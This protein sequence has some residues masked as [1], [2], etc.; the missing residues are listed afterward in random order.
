MGAAITRITYSLKTEN[1][2]FPTRTIGPRAVNRN[3]GNVSV[4][5]PLARILSAWPQKSAAPTSCTYEPRNCRILLGDEI[6]GVFQR[7]VAGINQVQLRLGEI[8]LVGFG[9]LDGEEWVVL[10]PDES[11]FSAGCLRKYSC[12]R[13][14]SATLD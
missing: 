6:A 9:S 14:Y 4:R 3:Y 2:I 12:Q 8:S 7:E 5:L 1:Y 11:A 13:S 10:S